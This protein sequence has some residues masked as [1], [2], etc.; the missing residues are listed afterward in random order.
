MVEKLRAR[1]ANVIIHGENWNAA[2]TLARKELN[3]ATAAGTSVHYI[4]PFDHP[5]LWEGHSS[6]V[7]ELAKDLEDG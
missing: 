7:D 2:D 1:G 3:D 6:I 5:L 4:P